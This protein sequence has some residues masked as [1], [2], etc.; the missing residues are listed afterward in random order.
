MKPQLQLSS[1]FDWCASELLID[2][3]KSQSLGTA[4]FLSLS[5]SLSQGAGG[6][7]EICRVTVDEWC[8]VIL[9]L[10]P[11]LQS[12]YSVWWCGG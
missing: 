10:L 5:L 8:S 3:V 4:L 6:L 11:V 1:W 9:R 2:L 12:Y 7:V